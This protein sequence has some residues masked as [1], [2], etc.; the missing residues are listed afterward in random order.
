M[1]GLR[2]AG[3]QRRVSSTWTGHQ[4]VISARLDTPA[5][6]ATSTTTLS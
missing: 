4:R 6:T 1:S 3:F 2:D 5:E